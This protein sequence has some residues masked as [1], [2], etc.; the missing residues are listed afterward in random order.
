MSSSTKMSAWLNSSSDPTARCTQVTSHKCVRSNALNFSRV[1]PTLLVASHPGD[2]AMVSLPSCGGL[3]TWLRRLRRTSGG[4]GWRRTRH[5]GRGCEWW[6]RR[7]GHA[8][9]R[10]QVAGLYMDNS[11]F[12]MNCV[13]ICKV[14]SC[15][16]LYGATFQSLF[17]CGALY[18][19][20][21]PPQASGAGPGAATAELLWLPFYDVTLL[22]GELYKKKCDPRI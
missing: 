4:R 20:R 14:C 11:V 13:C 19:A 9:P 3:T 5:E 21:L 10:P 8:R 15:V 7:T 12:C 1:S 2:N 22:R 16:V 17:L 18:A 6:T